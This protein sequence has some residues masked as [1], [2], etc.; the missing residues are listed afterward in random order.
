M[1][2]LIGFDSINLKEKLSNNFVVRE[3]VYDAVAIR[4]GIIN[5]PEQEHI[6]NAKHLAK[7]VLQP[8]RDHYGVP[9]VPNSWFRKPAFNV[10]VGSNNKSDHPK[11]MGADIEVAGVSNYDLACWI[12][13]N[14]SFKQIVLEY[15]SADDPRA[16]W[17]HVSS[18]EFEQRMECLTKTH[19]GWLRGF[20]V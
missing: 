2:T 20:V 3:M 6:D 17:V 19:N 10:A 9:I 14:C 18:D 13:D 16:G 7:T 4:L 15:P 11:G 8:V 1:T 12:R 5:L